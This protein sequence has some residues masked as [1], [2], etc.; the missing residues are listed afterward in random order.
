[1]GWMV[2][3]EDCS[4]DSY[5]PWWIVFWTTEFSKNYKQILMFVILVGNKESKIYLDL[6][7]P[8][9]V[10]IKENNNFLYNKI[11]SVFLVCYVLLWMGL[12]SDSVRQFLCSQVACYFLCEESCHRYIKTNSIP[13]DVS[14]NKIFSFVKSIAINSKY[15]IKVRQQ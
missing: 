6:V 11:V 7:W 5:L 9:E 12:G 2:C 14:K 15:M 1:M 4:L 8:F 3:T 13:W 10:C